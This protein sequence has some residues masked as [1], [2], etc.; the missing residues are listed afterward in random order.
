MPYHTW[1]RGR[2]Q[3]DIRKLWGMMDR[4]ITL[5]LVMVSWRYAYV[6][7]YQTVYIKYLQFLYINFT[8]VELL[9]TITIY[10]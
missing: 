9:K 10:F 3:R 4:F 8:S 2:K 7:T 1:G 6:Q 5:F